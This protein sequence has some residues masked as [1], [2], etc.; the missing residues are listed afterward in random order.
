M[1]NEQ[2]K[3]NECIKM[4]TH[5]YNLAYYKLY[6]HKLYNNFIK[7]DNNIIKTDI[8]IIKVCNLVLYNNTDT[9]VTNGID[10][11]SNININNNI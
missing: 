2:N 9:N 11:I 8:D 7:T 1:S 4:A 6:G 5:T 3:I 10:Y